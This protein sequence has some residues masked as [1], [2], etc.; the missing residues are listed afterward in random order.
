MAKE[1]IPITPL[2]VTWARSRAG[3][4]LEEASK[5]FKKIEAW[6]AGESFPTYRQLEQLADKFKIPVAVFF[7]PNPPSVPP[8]AES[9]R[10]LPEP[11]FSEI[12]RR[13]QFLLRKAKALQLNLKELNS[14]VN[15]APRLITRDLSFRR[16]VQVAK[17]A[18]DVRNYLGVTIE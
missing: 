9:F 11:Q 4:S 3:Y 5:I 12:P 1:Q 18:Q 14:G 10:T 7:F 8:I 16:D 2:I 17:M 6:E 15:P 13:I